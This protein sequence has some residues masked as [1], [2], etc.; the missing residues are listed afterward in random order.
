[1]IRETFF[2]RGLS[3]VDAEVPV[4]AP[5]IDVFFAF[6]NGAFNAELVGVRGDQ[7]NLEIRRASTSLHF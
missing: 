3:M 1:M 5:F 7:E 6:E 4:T 2:E